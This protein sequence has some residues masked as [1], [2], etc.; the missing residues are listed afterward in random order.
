MNG[1]Y[2]GLCAPPAR[3]ELLQCPAALRTY[4]APLRTPRN[5]LE[6]T[7]SSN[8]L[9]NFVLNLYFHLTSLLGLRSSLDLL[10]SV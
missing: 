6:K 10:P 1:I 9:S 2:E 5:E 3:A 8:N 7:V 4:E